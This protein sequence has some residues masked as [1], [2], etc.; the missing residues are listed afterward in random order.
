ML[1]R[2]LPAILCGHV[3]AL[4]GLA[5]QADGMSPPQINYILHCQ[6]CHLADGSGTPEKVPAL[7]NAA[8]RFLHVAGGREYLVQVPGTAQSALTDGEVAG[9]L[10]WIL[11]N[12]SKTELPTDFIPYSTE[13]ISRIRPHP[14]ANVS[15]T[16]A[17]LMAE[18]AAGTH[19]VPSPL[20]GKR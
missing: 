20:P 6:G 7:K 1:R 19:S 15:A 17:G 3:L 11:V 12:F 8:G 13:E 10:N 14:L 5:V 9:V 2:F 18:I 4:W 16:R